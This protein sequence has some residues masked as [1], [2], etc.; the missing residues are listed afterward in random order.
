MDIFIKAVAGVLVAAIVTLILAKQGKD[1]SVLLVICVCCMVTVT[2]LGYLQKIMD[3]LNLLQ[4]KGNLN[5][6]LIAIL[7][8][9]VGIGV[10]SEITGMICTDS[11]NAALGKVIQFLSASVILWLCIPLFTQLLELIESV[12]G[13]V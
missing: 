11:G 1:F 7:L 10:L 5:K 12:L 6:D 13:A 9:S 4:I 8:K 3:F 2:A